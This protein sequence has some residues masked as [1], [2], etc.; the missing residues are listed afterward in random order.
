MAPQLHS[1]EAF[2]MYR[3]PDSDTVVSIAQTSG[4]P[5][6]LCRFG[7]I[8]RHSGFVAAPFAITD[9]EPVVIIRPDIV[10]ETHVDD[11]ADDNIE[12]PKTLV[13]EARQ[14]ENR[15]QYGSVFKKFH[16]MLTSGEYRKIVLARSEDVFFDCQPLEENMQKTVATALF[17][18]ACRRYPHQ[19]V[20]LISTEKTGLWLMAT[21]EILLTMRSREGRSM[22]LA[23]TIRVDDVCSGADGSGEKPVWTQKNRDEQQVVAQ[24]ISQRLKPFT[25]KIAVS[26]PHTVRASNVCH[27]QTDFL[28]TLADGATTADIISELH[29]TPA[30]C[31][32]PKESAQR[33]IV[34]N[35][36][37]RRSYYSGFVGELAL[38]GST[39]LYVSLRC[40]QI[41]PDR[42]RLYAGGGLMKESV[43]EQEWQETCAKMQAMKELF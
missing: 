16:S 9:S 10:T 4:K 35:E 22:A 18:R 3:L 40:M 14:A 21:P 42:F 25:E 37:C 34:D 23:G 41:L 12:I 8:D 17:H 24:Y 32:L 15:L 38:N 36:S 30:V 28:F 39:N 20:A 43:E 6:E 19:F 29:P 2:A 27:L 26:N 5:E 33:F 31:G 7:D 13:D 1:Y 11:I